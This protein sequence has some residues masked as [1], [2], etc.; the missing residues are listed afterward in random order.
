MDSIYRLKLQGAIYD[1]SIPH[2]GHRFI[3]EHDLLDIEGLVIPR[4]FSDR[5][6]HFI[7]PLPLLLEVEEEC[8]YSFG[9]YF[10]P[11]Q[12]ALPFL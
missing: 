6:H 1:G 11:R 3:R 9:D 12:W 2:G 5:L 8:D 4:F 10:S 7:R